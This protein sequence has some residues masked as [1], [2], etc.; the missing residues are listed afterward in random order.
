M[1]SLDSF[2]NTFL[3]TF[4]EKKFDYKQQEVALATYGR[5]LVLQCHDQQV[6]CK[7]PSICT[8]SRIFTSHLHL[9][10]LSTYLDNFLTSFL[11]L[12]HT[13]QYISRL[14]VKKQL[15]DNQH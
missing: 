13:L 15:V 6:F 11:L 1:E 9:K 12:K 14:H 10:F 7:E 3:P 8:Q 5:F 4:K 2:L